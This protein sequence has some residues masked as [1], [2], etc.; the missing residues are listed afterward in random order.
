[1]LSAQIC[2]WPGSQ[3]LE[4]GAL[5]PGDGGCP[6]GTQDNWDRRSK[7][8][9]ARS[10]GDRVPTSAYELSQLLSLTLSPTQNPCATGLPLGSGADMHSG[11]ALGHRRH[12]AN[13][14]RITETMETA[15]GCHQSPRSEECATVPLGVMSCS[16][17]FGV[18]V[19]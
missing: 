11:V 8:Q 6:Q 2:F 17:T 14:G 10:H 3:T 4:Q 13:P 7:S 16:P 1:M 15:Q 12:H 19:M 5:W 18:E 9:K